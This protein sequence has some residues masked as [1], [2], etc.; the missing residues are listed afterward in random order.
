VWEKLDDSLILSEVEEQTIMVLVVSDTLRGR[1]R[2]SWT[3]A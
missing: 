1:R 2:K 3:T